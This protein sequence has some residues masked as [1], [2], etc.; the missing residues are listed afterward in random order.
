[1]GCCEC[2]EERQETRNHLSK[3]SLHLELGTHPAHPAQKRGGRKPVGSRACDLDWGLTPAQQNRGISH[4]HHGTPRVAVTGTGRAE[5]STD[6]TGET[7]GGSRAAEGEDTYCQ[8]PVSEKVQVD[9]A[10]RSCRFVLGQKVGGRRSLKGKPQ[11]VWK[12]P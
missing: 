12:P 5:S 1:M 6:R 3:Q 7:S 4:G 9:K 11:L 8:R 10:W 2:G